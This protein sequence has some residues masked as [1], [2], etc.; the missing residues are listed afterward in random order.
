MR[1]PSTAARPRMVLLRSGLDL[2]AHPSGPGGEAQGEREIGS[3]APPRRERYGSC[4]QRPRSRMVVSIGPTVLIDA[5]G[6]HVLRRRGRRPLAERGHRVT[7]LDSATG[8]V[9]HARE[10]DTRG[11]YVVAEAHGFPL[12]TAASTSSSRTTRCRWS[13]T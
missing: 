9:Q 11:L 1:T 12:E 10:A 3:S 13:R 7:A 8:L 5:S 6:E 4:A 2:S